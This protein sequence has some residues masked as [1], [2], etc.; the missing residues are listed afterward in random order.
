MAHRA[1]VSSAAAMVDVRRSS[2][3]GVAALFPS[4]SDLLGPTSRNKH[5]ARWASCSRPRAADV[6]VAV[7]VVRVVAAELRSKVALLNSKTRNAASLAP[8]ALRTRKG[9]SARTAHLAIAVRDMT[10]HAAPD[11]IVHRVPNGP[12]AVPVVRLDPRSLRQPKAP[13]LPPMPRRANAAVS[14]AVVAEEAVVVRVAAAV[15]R[16]ANKRRPSW[17]S[18]PRAWIRGRG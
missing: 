17:D 13:A 15:R 16:K 7:A 14:V 18:F 10:V 1:T 9:P 8:R 5:R 11:L 12:T 2:S 6:A 4:N 3:R